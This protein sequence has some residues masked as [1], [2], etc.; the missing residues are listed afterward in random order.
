M[1][2]SAENVSKTDPG[3]VQAVEHISFSLMKIC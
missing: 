2:L 3:G 1:V